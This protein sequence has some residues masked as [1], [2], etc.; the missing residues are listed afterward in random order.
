MMASFG[1]THYLIENYNNL[2]ESVKTSPALSYFDPFQAK[3]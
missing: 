2:S 3:L 1:P